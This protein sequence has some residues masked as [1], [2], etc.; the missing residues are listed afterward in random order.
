M[1]DGDIITFGAHFSAVFSPMKLR[2]HLPMA[3]VVILIAVICECALGWV[4]CLL[5]CVL[6][7][8]VVYGISTA[9]PA[10]Y[11]WL[12]D[13][14]PVCGGSLFVRWW[15]YRGSTDLTASFSMR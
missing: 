15:I 3:R 9:I 4:G 14:T 5:P 12:F 11:T 1:H 13:L 6:H 10:R 8:F 2:L 7:L